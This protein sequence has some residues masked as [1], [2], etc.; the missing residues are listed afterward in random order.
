MS[1][2]EMTQELIDHYGS[3]RAAARIS[4]ISTT[5][6]YEIHKGRTKD[7]RVSTHN[8]LKLQIE[9]ARSVKNGTL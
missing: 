1:Y 8:Q 7:P 4:G 2:Q 3:L 5:T 9:K 6:F